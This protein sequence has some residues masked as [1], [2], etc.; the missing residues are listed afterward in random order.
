MELVRADCLSIDREM[1]AGDTVRIVNGAPYTDMLAKQ[2]AAGRADPAGGGLSLSR[3]GLAL[4][5]VGRGRIVDPEAAA[6]TFSDFVASIGSQIRAEGIRADVFDE[7]PRDG[8]SD[9]LTLARQASNC[10]SVIY[11]GGAKIHADVSAANP[12]ES[13]DRMTLSQ[14]AF[15]D[16]GAF[17]SVER[18]LASMTM[19]ERDTSFRTSVYELASSMDEKRRGPWH[20]ALSYLGDARISAG[21]SDAERAWRGWA[22]TASLAAY[23]AS[24]AAENALELPVLPSYGPLRDESPSAL[25]ARPN[26]Q[27]IAEWSEISIRQLADAPRDELLTLVKMLD[28]AGDR[29][30]Q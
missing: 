12:F 2:E 15:D 11:Y 13:L 3:V 9:R 19:S 21:M 4:A 23:G 20:E 24:V 1:R 29:G 22:S 7:V 14:I 10:V 25:V 18:H 8:S 6:A 26:A 30:D 28:S 27:G 5:S 17:T 16:S